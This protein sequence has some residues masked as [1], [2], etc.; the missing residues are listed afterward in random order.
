MLRKFRGTRRAGRSPLTWLAPICR[1]LERM[2]Q[3]KKNDCS[4]FRMCICCLIE[5]TQRFWHIPHLCNTMVSFLRHMWSHHMHK[6][7][8]H[9]RLLVYKSI[10]RE[11]RTNMQKLVQIKLVIGRRNILSFPGKNVF[12]WVVRGIKSLPVEVCWHRD[13]EQH[14]IS[15]WAKTNKSTKAFNNALE[16]LE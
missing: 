2:C 13:E 1:R 4:K 9:I 12:H 3:E 16:P 11:G 8:P 14:V 10:N 15:P 6:E 7:P 5:S